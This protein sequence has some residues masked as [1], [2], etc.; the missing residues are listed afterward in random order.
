MLN[1]L[2]ANYESPDRAL[3]TAEPVT[4]AQLASV[5]LAVHSGS[6]SRMVLLAKGLILV[7]RS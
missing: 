6:L 7:H 5:V 3:F 1:E 4:P 2:T